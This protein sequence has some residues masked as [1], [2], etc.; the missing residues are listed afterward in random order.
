MDHDRDFASVIGGNGAEVGGD[1][2]RGEA[3]AGAQLIVE[4]RGKF[5][6]KAGADFGE[7]VR[8]D[9]TSVNIQKIVSGTVCG[10]L[11]WKNC[12]CMEKFDFELVGQHF[13]GR[14]S[15]GGRPRDG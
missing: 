2:F 11:S 7:V 5:D 9:D 6:C 10:C 13:G 12:V 8:V 4:V 15:S 14:W 3:A 1:V